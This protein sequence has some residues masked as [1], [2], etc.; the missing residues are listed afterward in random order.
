MGRQRN[1]PQKKEQE[2][3]PEELDEMEGSNL[4]NTEFTIMIIRILNNMKKDTESIKKE[5]VINKECNI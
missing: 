4:S 5:R 1:R 2:N 3:F